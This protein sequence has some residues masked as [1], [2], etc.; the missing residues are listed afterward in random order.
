MTTQT[1]A[2]GFG[3]DAALQ[4]IRGAA[5]SY[6]PLFITRYFKDSDN[7]PVVLADFHVDVLNQIEE[8]IDKEP[9]DPTR[10]NV[11]VLLPAAHGKTTNLSRFLPIKRIC[12]NPNVRIM[13]IMNNS[14]DA[15]QNLAAIQQE[16]TDEKLLLVQEWG[17]F[18]GKVWKATEFHVAGRSI[19]DKDPTFAAYGTG[20]NVFGHRAD[21]VICD[22]I[23]TLDNAG[24]FASD[25]TRQATEDWFFQGVMKVT[26]PNGICIVIGTVMDYRDLYHK[27]M[28]MPEK[29]KVIRLKAILDDATKQVLWP[30]RFSYDWLAAERATDMTAFLKRFQNIAL[31]TSLLTFPVE[32]MQLCR[33]FNRR[34][35]EITEEMRKEGATQVINGFDPT[36][37]QTRKSKWCGFFS[38]AFNPKQPEP[39]KYYALELQHFRAPQEVTEDEWA[40]GKIGQVNFLI[41]K[42]KTY[43]ARETVIEA[44]GAH[45][46]LL[47]NNMLKAFR[48]SGNNVTPHYT[49][50][51]NKPDP[52]IGLPSLSPIVR[53]HLIDFPYGDELS[54]KWVD[55]FFE[56]EMGQ[57]PMADTTDILM[58]MWFAILRA[59]QLGGSGRAVIR[60]PLPGWAG[61]AGLGQGFKRAVISR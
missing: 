4:A 61:G 48:D 38:L 39:R 20:T 1:Q 60:R 14:T 34:W 7:K 31:E 26:A 45:Q 28:K 56:N 30:A 44:N 21:I 51:K 53:A 29:W 17:P 25:R 27:L 24:P 6:T 57:H 35:G 9:S 8:E 42:H 23:L 15:E 3:S 22:D 36:A 10:R 58:A 19:I 50:D 54:R 55:Y 13:H 47:Q 41:D 2:L 16:L 11:L 33:N 18:K 59:K 37:G 43:R 46:F 40:A 32:D 49:H 5:L 52:L 12:Q